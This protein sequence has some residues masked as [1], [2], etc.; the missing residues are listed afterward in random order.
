[1]DLVH[2]VIAAAMAGHV[3]FI[4]LADGRERYVWDAVSEADARDDERAS[5]YYAPGDP[6]APSD[7]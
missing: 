1:M 6:E 3:P 4:S 5:R 2:P 7:D